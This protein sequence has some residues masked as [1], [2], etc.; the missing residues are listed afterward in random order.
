MSKRVPELFLFDIIVA[1][2]KIKE[3]SQNF[4]SGQDLKSSFIHWDAVIRELEIIGEATNKLIKSGIFNTKMRKIV[5]FRNMI[6]HEY[7]GIDEDIVWNVVQE[8][9]DE[10]FNNVLD[11]IRKVEEPLFTELKETVMKENIHISFV[12]EFLK[13]LD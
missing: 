1:I 7:F 11:E 5:D 13:S 9:L 4:N 12:V 2:L 6:I 10:L 3:I 8:H